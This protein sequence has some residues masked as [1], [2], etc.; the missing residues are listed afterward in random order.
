M[1]HTEKPGFDIDVAKG[2]VLS[3]PEE[4]REPLLI[5]LSMFLK[6]FVA[7]NKEQLNFMDLDVPV[8]DLRKV[9]T[10]EQLV[11]FLESL[12]FKMEGEKIQLELPVMQISGMIDE[13]LNEFKN[14]ETEEEDKNQNV[15]MLAEETNSDVIEIMC[16]AMNMP[17]SLIEK[18]QE[19]EDGEMLSEGTV[20]FK[21]GSVVF[22]QAG[23]GIKTEWRNKKL[24]NGYDIGTYLRIYKR[25]TGVQIVKAGN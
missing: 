24:F 11:V 4:K 16:R 8:D 18:M 1:K 23:G 5:A 19:L 15:L 7:Y 2:L 20:L 10:E 6:H 13:L 25:G 22:R 12:G 3:V 14:D 21:F 9:L 17:K